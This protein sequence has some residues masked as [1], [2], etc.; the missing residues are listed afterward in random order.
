M[1]NQLSDELTAQNLD[2]LCTELMS[3]AHGA[4]SGRSA[5]GVFNGTYLRQVLLT[6][7]EG[8]ELA[9]HDSPPEATLQVVR[10]SV[11]LATA[12]ESWHLST[13]DL[14]AVP[15]DRHSVAAVTDAAFMLTIRTEIS[16][17]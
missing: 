2:E 17:G 12:T 3:R 15:P 16:G 10:G 6:L 4:R 11:R 1:R 8:S 5:R 9:D 14:I 7:T 13:G